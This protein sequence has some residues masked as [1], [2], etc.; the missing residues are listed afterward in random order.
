[1]QNNLDIVD[2]LEM[3][4]LKNNPVAVGGKGPKE[5]QE[6]IEKRL[7]KHLIT[8]KYKANLKFAIK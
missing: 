8:H 2:N 5:M 1:M 7:R 3:R 6:N 4:V